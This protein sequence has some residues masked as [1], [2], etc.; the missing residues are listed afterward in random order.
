MRGSHPDGDTSE[1]RAAPAAVARPC[2][3]PAATD[4]IWRGTLK[5]HGAVRPVD[6]ASSD[7]GRATGVQSKRERHEGRR[8]GNAR[9]GQ[10]GGKPLKTEEEPHGRSRVQAP[11]RSGEEQ[12]V[13]VVETTMCR[14]EPSVS[15]GHESFGTRTAPKPVVANR[16]RWTRAAFK[17]RRGTKPRRGAAEPA[18][19]S[20]FR[21]MPHREMPHPAMTGEAADLDA[22][23]RGGVQP[24]ERRTSR[25]PPT[26]M[27]G[28]R[29]A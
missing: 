10:A 20:P 2:A 27:D 19:E 14:E 28:L 23:R 18:D 15:R 1:W 13:E 3:A 5:T 25:S 21:N 4:P 6:S 8:C 7:G 16:R 9:S 26:G 17:R 24:Q 29:R 11:G 12:V 22:G